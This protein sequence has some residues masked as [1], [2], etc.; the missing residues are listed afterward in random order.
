MEGRVY[1]S[2]SKAS[3]ALSNS[4]K[5]SENIDCGAK[6]DAGSPGPIRALKGIN[7]QYIR[8]IIE[9]LIS[10]IFQNLQYMG[11]GRLL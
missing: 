11:P 2:P 7:K 6:F 3:F 8:K 4:S 10:G 1:V 9:L 5:E